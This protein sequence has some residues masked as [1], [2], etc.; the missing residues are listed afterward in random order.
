MTTSDFRPEESV[1]NKHLHLLIKLLSSGWSL[2]LFSFLVAG[3][4]GIALSEALSFNVIDGWCQNS[5]Q[6]G[7]GLH[8][9]GDFGHPFYKGGYS[10]VYQ[11]GNIVAVNSPSVMLMFE[12][13][14]LLPYRIALAAFLSIGVFSC[15]W[16][17]YIAAKQTDSRQTSLLI[18]LIVFGS[19]GFISAFDRANPILFM[20]GLVY[21]MMSAIS[22]DNWRGATV[23]VIALASIKFWAP[24]FLICWIASRRYR[25][26]LHAIVGIA[27]SYLI[28]MSLFPG[29]YFDNLRVMFSSILDQNTIKNFQPFAI[30]LSSL[31]RRIFCAAFSRDTCQTHAFDWGFLAS[32]VFGISIALLLSVVAF[33]AFTTFAQSPFLAFTPVTALTFLAVPTAQSYN[34]IIMI[35]LAALVIR[36]Q[37]RTSRSMPNPVSIALYRVVIGA[38]ALTT[39]PL[40][41]FY[42]GD[43]VFSSSN[44][45]PPVFRLVYWLAPA[46]WF[47]VFI[48]YSR[49]IMVR[50]KIR[51]FSRWSE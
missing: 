45:G 26:F 21:W 17:V 36:D 49:E 5:F 51:A 23:A 9:F 35:P 42:F 44:S 39:S 28:P 25:Y 22:K 29:K 41:F 11:Y 8:C 31:I 33:F 4:Y 3:Y 50:P 40:A 13:L 47:V 16:P 34:L 27:G 15:T 32:P 7:I 46:T 14:G 10:E 43:S 6:D 12:I 38:I 48:F 19:F 20:P 1:E 37:G 2:S 24:V 30:S 18:F